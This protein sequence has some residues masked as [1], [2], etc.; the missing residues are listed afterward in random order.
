M[1]FEDLSKE[2][3]NKKILNKNKMIICGDFNVKP[4]KMKL[5]LKN[6]NKSTETN[7]GISDQKGLE[8]HKDGN[9]IDYILSSSISNNFYG[10]NMDKS[11]T[12]HKFICTSWN[13]GEFKLEHKS[14]TSGHIFNFDKLNDREVRDKIRLELQLTCEHRSKELEKLLDQES[15]EESSVVSIIKKYRSNLI[16]I[17]KDNLTYKKKVLFQQCSIIFQKNLLILK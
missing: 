11:I 7:I 10:L 13:D 17:L 5:I 2:I 9:K 14:K 8:T 16:D 3:L 6:F 4:D 12:D 15:L 1:A